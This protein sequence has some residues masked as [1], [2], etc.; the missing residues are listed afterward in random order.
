MN[1]IL[2][3]VSVFPSTSA[4]FVLNEMLKL[5]ERGF[6]IEIIS[7][8]KPKNE[9]FQPGIEEF[10]KVTYIPHVKQNKM[11]GIK[12]IGSNFKYLLHNP[13]KYISGL[14]C[15]IKGKS[16]N[17]FYDFL[18]AV[19]LIQ[20]I[21]LS[22][23]NHI[24]SQ[25]AHTPTSL[26]YFI[27]ILINKQYSF[28][29]HAVD[30]FVQN[31]LF[32]EKLSRSKFAVTI[33]DFNKNYINDLVEDKA[34]TNKI[35][36][37]RC[38]VN[39]EEFKPP[40]KKQNNNRVRLLS[41]GR[42][43]EKKGFIYLVDA[44]KILDQKGINFEC[45]IIGNGPLF[46]MIKCK[47]RD[48]ELDNKINLLGAQSSGKI[49]EYLCKAD[50]FVLPCVKSE[51]GDMDGIPVSIME[52]MSF[53]IPVISTNISGIPE[54]IKNE[55]NGL[56]VEEK[57]SIEFANAIQLLIQNNQLRSIYG[58]NGRNFIIKEFG[59]NENVHKLV[60]LFVEIEDSK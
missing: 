33:S 52:A 35:K 26:A 42:F 27:S 36:I 25:F 48:Y 46:E 31:S 15:A 2:Y 19:Y 13:K 56:I 50:I 1:K 54:L 53:E 8:R 11:D 44:L 14:V 28:T 7:L 39:Y 20:N 45:D 58:Q 17:L 59:I 22:E 30:I 23:I 51:N 12:L 60:E 6:E 43:V 55:E 34:L 4:T 24:H 37:I 5:K 38:G 16:Y 41:V 57:N 49:K 9:I 21:D 29:C 32:E 47:V 3:V 18:R 40:V 10:K